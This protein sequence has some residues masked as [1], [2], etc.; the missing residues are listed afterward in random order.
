LSV[1][2]G[3]PDPISFSPPSDAS[4]VPDQLATANQVADDTP[5]RTR[6]FGRYMGQISA[7]IERA[8]LK[9]RDPVTGGTFACRVT[10]VQGATGNI[11]QI[12]LEQCGAEPRW[13]RSL[14]AAIQ[15]AAPLPAPPDPAV[16]TSS[17]RMAFM[18]NAFVPGGRQEGFES[19]AQAMAARDDSKAQLQDLID[20]MRARRNAEP[21]VTELRI[22]GTPQPGATGGGTASQAATPEPAQNGS[23]N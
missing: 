10:I 18:A 14:I 2:L 21:G 11:E 19:E 7:R 12:S 20:S 9:P 17:V 22:V 8:W 1:D 3:E 13:R 15:S 23:G 16:F 6:L 5:E 4:V